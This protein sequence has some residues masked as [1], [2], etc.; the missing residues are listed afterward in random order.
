MHSRVEIGFDEAS[1]QGRGKGRFFVGTTQGSIDV[2]APWFQ[3]C[4]AYFGFLVPRVAFWLLNG[5]C[6][7]GE[8]GMRLEVTVRR[9]RENGCVFA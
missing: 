4:H 9:Y 2:L 5:E 3:L 1:N 6:F 7:R 8:G